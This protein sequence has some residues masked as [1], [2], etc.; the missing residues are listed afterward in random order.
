[1]DKILVNKGLI[2]K[3]L[4]TNSSSKGLDRKGLIKDLID[5]VNILMTN[6]NKIAVSKDLIKGLIDKN[7]VSK[8]NLVNLVNSGVK[9]RCSVL[10]ATKKL[11]TSQRKGYGC[12]KNAQ[13]HKREWTN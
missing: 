13:K 10:C 9:Q 4:A 11:Y 1:M 2:D 7:L 5:K 8:V 6:V 3:D 12:V